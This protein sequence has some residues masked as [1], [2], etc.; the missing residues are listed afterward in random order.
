MQLLAALIIIAFFLLLLGAA[1]Y[2][3]RTQKPRAQH[4]GSWSR[5]LGPQF[6]GSA[7]DVS[8]RLNEEI[9]AGQHQ[10]SHRQTRRVRQT[11]RARSKQR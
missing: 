2:L 11:H 7:L 5:V 4:Y 10:S 8:E 6:R 9:S 1:V 3:A